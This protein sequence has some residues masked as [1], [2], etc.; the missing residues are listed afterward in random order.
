MSRDVE[1]SASVG[2]WQSLGSVPRWVPCERVAARGWVV[3]SRAAWDAMV[4]GETLISLVEVLVRWVCLGEVCP[5]R[6]GSAVLD[7]VCMDGRE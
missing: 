6:L 1:S 2:R 7:Q 4:C 5:A 3:A